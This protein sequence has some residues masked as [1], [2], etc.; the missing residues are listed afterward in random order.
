MSQSLSSHVDQALVEIPSTVIG[1]V[2]AFEVSARLEMSGCGDRFAQG[3]GYESVFEHAQAVW[4]WT[5]IPADSPRDPS[6]FGEAL[7]RS[8]FVLAG[9]ALCLSIVDQDPVAIALTGVAA[10]VGSIVV[11]SVLWWGHGRGDRGMGSRVGLG[12]GAVVIIAGVIGSLATGDPAVAVAALWGITAG[13]GMIGSIR[14][15]WVGLV[16]LAALVAVLGHQI[17]GT[18]FDHIPGLTVAVLV[19]IAA[20]VE[21]VPRARTTPAEAAEGAL[22]IGL[23]STVQVLSQV[24]ALVGLVLQAGA[25]ATLVVVA[26][27]TVTGLAEPL[28]EFARMVMSWSTGRLTSIAGARRATGAVGV[29]WAGSLVAVGVG[30][31][32]L[33]APMLGLPL[34][35]VPLLVTITTCGIVA[36]VLVMLGTGS[37]VGAV[38][39]SCTA[40]AATWA[41]ILVAPG[42]LSALAATSIVVALTVGARRLAD[43]AVW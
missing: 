2:D 23:L 32:M 43:P 3:L 11:G 12:L 15:P 27:L 38:V 34:A 17:P 16:L 40:A 9:V 6:R 33:A 13:I 37:Q 22:M 28:Q 19:A 5:E 30:A 1:A 10:W 36:S 24:G 18:E 21:E 14:L 39:L 8:L 42:A 25:S 31:A 4:H 26:T 41:V 20:L 29:L 35:E 7:K